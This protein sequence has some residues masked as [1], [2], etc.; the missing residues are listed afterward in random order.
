[1]FI[2]A[3]PE[4]QDSSFSSVTYRALKGALETYSQSSAIN[5]TRPQ[6]L[7]P[8]NYRTRNERNLKNFNDS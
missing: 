1:M 3:R 4:Y 7:K 2:V 6:A 8:E 5:I